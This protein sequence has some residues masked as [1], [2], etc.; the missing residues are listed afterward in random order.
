MNLIPHTVAKK[1]TYCSLSYSVCSLG[2]EDRRILGLL[3]RILRLNFTRSLKELH[4]FI[5]I[6]R[7]LYTIILL[8]QF[9]MKTLLITHF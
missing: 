9:L 8:L 6:L 7:L 5:I 4:F 3:C 1:V 2:I